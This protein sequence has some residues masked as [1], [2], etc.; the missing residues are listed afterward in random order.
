MNGLKLMRWYSC[1]TPTTSFTGHKYVLGVDPCKKIQPHIKKYV[2]VLSTLVKKSK[3]ITTQPH[4]KNNNHTA[5]T[6]A[7]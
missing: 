5:K 2:L 3:K 7:P 1:I 6:T 4:S